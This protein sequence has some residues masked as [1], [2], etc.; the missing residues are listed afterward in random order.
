LPLFTME[1][2]YLWATFKLEDGRVLPT[3]PFNSRAIINMYGTLRTKTPRRLLQ[4]VVAHT[5]K[6]YQ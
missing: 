1:P 2:P 5:L 6:L 4:D 3:F